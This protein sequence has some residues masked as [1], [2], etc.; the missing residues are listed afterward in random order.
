MTSYTFERDI[1]ITEIIAK[2]EEI[3]GLAI[4]HEKPGDDYIFKD[5]NIA[6]P[7]NIFISQ[8]KRTVDLRENN[9]DILFSLF[10]YTLHLMGGQSFAE[11]DEERLAE[12]SN[13]FPINV[14][15]ERKNK[16]KA[17]LFDVMILPIIIIIYLLFLLFFVIMRFFDVLL[18]LATL[19]YLI[20]RALVGIKDGK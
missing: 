17:M 16:R 19:P 5:E 1:T 14:K 6:S 2:A 13:K 18:W 12:L 3:C 20:V 11:K 15:A 7:V 8:D 9:G 4:A 10:D